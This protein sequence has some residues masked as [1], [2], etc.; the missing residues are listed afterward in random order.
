[1]VVRKN[2]QEIWLAANARRLRRNASQK[3]A[4]RDR[5]KDTCRDI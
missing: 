1:V 2:E 3:S 4:S 5:Q